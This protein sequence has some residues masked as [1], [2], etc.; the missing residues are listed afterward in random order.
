MERKVLDVLKLALVKNYVPPEFIHLW[1]GQDYLFCQVHRYEINE[2]ENRFGID[3][4]IAIEVNGR[5]HTRQFGM[6][7]SREKFQLHIITRPHIK[8]FYFV[9]KM[10]DNRIVQPILALFKDVIR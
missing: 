6:T 1:Q 8:H 2:R 9:P 4:S 10:D 7:T 3:F 5:I